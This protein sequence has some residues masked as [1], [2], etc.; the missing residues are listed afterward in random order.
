MT[1]NILLTG[2]GGEGVLVTSVILAKAANLDGYEVRGTQLHGLAQR[3][4]SIPTHL[5]LGKKVYSPIIPRS[6]ADLIL[7][8]EPIEAARACFYAGSHKTN[9]II[10]TYPLRPIYAD[11]LGQKYP[12]NE[13]ISKMIE[14][15][16]KKLIMVDASNIC[17]K[18]LGN[19]IFG[20]VMCVG[21]ALANDMLPISE[22]N[23]LRSL[24]EI[25]PR[26]LEKNLKAFRMGMD[27]KG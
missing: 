15:F 10:D 21:V 25:V 9:F 17:Y 23:V 13:S 2:V 11:L 20:N 4:G 27:F 7:G 18:K 8:L 14:P 19:P 5:R 24:K 12:S 22:K 26:G 6:E 3:G 1:Y 16:A